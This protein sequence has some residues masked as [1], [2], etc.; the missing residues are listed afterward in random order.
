MTLV[1]A[2]DLGTS[3][4]KAGLIDPTGSL[5]ATASAAYPTRLIDGGGA[6]QDPED[7]IRCA[8]E[9]IGELLAADASRAARINALALTGQMQDLVLLP[10]GPG[11]ARRTPAPAVLYT[12]TRAGSDAARLHDLLPTWE[13][14][15]GNAQ[16]ATSCAAMWHRIGR[17]DPELVDSV[18]HVVFGPAG[19]LAWALGCGAWC[20]A[21]TASTTG[22]LDQRTGTWSPEVCA[23]A[24]IGPR[25]LP[26]LTDRF[27]AIVGFTSDD[28]H[29]LLGL[30]TGIPVVLAPG[31]AAATTL[32]ITGPE[33]GAVHAYLGTS[34]WIA[35]VADP[36][37]RHDVTAVASHQLALAGTTASAPTLRISALL[38]AG[39]TADWARTTLLGAIPFLEADALLD[40]RERERGRGP[41]G[42]LAL[43]SL[44]GERF[45]VRDES[46]RAAIIGIDA[47]TRPIDLYVSVLE[48]VA[49]A[50]SHALPPEGSS[51]AVA[52]GGAASAPWLRVLADATGRVITRVEDA[53]APVMGAAIAAA[54]AV[55][56]D[57]RML[58]LAARGD[59]QVTAPDPE[60]SRRYA[61][62][63]ER[64]RALYD[65]L[66]GLPDQVENGVALS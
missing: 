8:R 31:D 38:S 40:A 11:T 55:G 61:G 4:A 53:D 9:A 3:A 44:Q 5:V 65:A 17:T 41:T 16:D 14:V 30:T 66:G 45:P 52:G 64:H 29:E 54:D 27:G 56:I 57:H 12:D 32:G 6:E 59:N 46:L 48:G 1:L 21:T 26:A 7:W 42:L 23:A 2:L 62:A 10:D 58:P 24:G 36:R 47:R 63:R 13:R 34:G 33:P 35:H 37:Q 39:A 18:R 25:L 20:D 19:F 51:L 43:P 60:A 49:L 22:L 28:A 15:T 50:L